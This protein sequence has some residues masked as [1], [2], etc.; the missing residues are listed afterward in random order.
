MATTN[1]TTRLKAGVLILG[2]RV[3]VAFL[4]KRNTVVLHLR[5]GA[6]M[7]VVHLMFRWS[8]RSLWDGG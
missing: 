5:F 6:P 8:G 3:S 1:P 7:I 2:I 4:V